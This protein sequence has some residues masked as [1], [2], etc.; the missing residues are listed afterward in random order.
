[1]FLEDKMATTTIVDGSVYVASLIDT[2]GNPT[3]SI[4][5]DTITHDAN[6]AVEIYSA[7]IEY[8]YT[9]DV[10][11]IA[12][13]SKGK[14]D[15]TK[16]RR[17]IDLKRIIKTITVTGVLD[18][19]TSLRAITKRNDLLNMG[20]FQRTLTLVWG[21][22]NYRTIFDPV[23]NADKIGVFILKMRFR[24]TAGIFGVPVLGDPQ[25]FTKTNVEITLVVGKDI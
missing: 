16:P 24:E 2:D 15:E 13:K 18:D 3:G 11:G 9:D 8:N 22:G 6:K 10:G 7:R 19:E 12:F 14:T 4:S 25:P 20:E 21:N 23:S 5:G 17:I 1:M